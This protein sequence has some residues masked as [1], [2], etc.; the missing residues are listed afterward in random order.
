MRTAR[1]SQFF[2][3][4]A[5]GLRKH[6]MLLG[7]LSKCFIS[8][9]LHYKLMA[10]IFDWSKRR[11]R[12]L[13][14]SGKNSQIELR[15]M[16]ARD[17]DSTSNCGLIALPPIKGCKTLLPPHQYNLSGVNLLVNHKRPHQE[18]F[19]NLTTTAHRQQDDR[20]VIHFTQRHGLPQLHEVHHNNI[21]ASAHEYRDDQHRRNCLL[22]NQASS[23]V[24]LE[25]NNTM[26]SGTNLSIMSESIADEKSKQFHGDC[27]NVDLTLPK[28]K[29]TS[30][31]RTTNIR[32]GK[33]SGVSQNEIILQSNGV[34]G[35]PNSPHAGMGHNPISDG[36]L[37]SSWLSSGGNQDL[38]AKEREVLYHAA[39]MQP[40]S[41]VDPTCSSPSPN[42]EVDKPKPRRN[43]RISKDP[44]SVAARQRRQRISSKMR[45]LQKLVPGGVKMDTASM[46]EE[47]AHYLKFLRA[48]VEKMEAFEQL[49]NVAKGHFDNKL[50]AQAAAP[51]DHN[52]LHGP[53]SKITSKSAAPHQLALNASSTS[54]QSGLLCNYRVPSSSSVQASHTYLTQASLSF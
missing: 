11:E 42:A 7:S 24:G 23:G 33:V 45:V 49:M 35:A 53:Q 32:M 2:T 18:A 28:D 54:S 3:A 40:I 50:L 31:P 43:V 12:Q 10:E 22:Q 19:N 48:E 20:H 30:S 26:K 38:S 51:H 5:T 6:F 27:V 8:A 9:S 25:Y 29:A 1:G 13:L 14:Q 41:E 36:K 47:A 17:L 46:L 15:G 37:S 4:I 44:Q 21:L 16:C 52:I 39:A 34:L